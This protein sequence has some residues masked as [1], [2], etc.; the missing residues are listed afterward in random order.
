M[1][2]VN[3]R[4]WGERENRLLPCSSPGSPGTRRVMLAVLPLTTSQCNPATGESGAGFGCK[5]T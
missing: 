2:T 3:S 1:G 5:V 4:G